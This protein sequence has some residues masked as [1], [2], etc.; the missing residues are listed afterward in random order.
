MRLI[1][2]AGTCFTLLAYTTCAEARDPQRWVPPPAPQV[3][4]GTRIVP[5]AEVFDGTDF[6]LHLPKPDQADWRQ[7][8]YEVELSRNDEQ[9]FMA[10]LQTRP[11]VKDD[12]V[13]FFTI[14]KDS[15]GKFNIEVIDKAGYPY[16]KVW[17]GPLD[18]IKVID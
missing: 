15:A 4:E 2:L 18:A 5:A 12:E 6:I 11:F 3:V 10:T 7:T 9:R 16:K 17:S 13:V 8:R 14:P 1:C